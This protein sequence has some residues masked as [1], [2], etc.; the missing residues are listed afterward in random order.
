MD[1]TRLAQRNRQLAAFQHRLTWREKFRRAL[2]QAYASL[3]SPLLQKPKRGTI[4]LIRPDHLGDV[5][6]TTPTIQALRQSSRLPKDAQLVGLVGP[7]S[8]EA[9]AA[10]PELDLVLTLPFPGFTRKPKESYLAPYMQAFQ[11]ARKVRQL[12]AEAAIILRP[13]HWW[14][15]M[16][17]YLAGVPRRIGYDLPD[18]R[19]F[20]TH[21]LPH[22]PDHTVMQSLR[23]VEWWTGPINRRDVRLSFPVADADRQYIN[24]LLAASGVPALR[25]IV[26]IHPGAGTPLKRW[27]PEHWAQVA[28]RLADRLD[29]TVVFTGSD[30]EHTQIWQ[31][32]NKMRHRGLSL[33]GD[34]NVPQLAAL[35]ARAVVALGPDSGPLHLAVASGTPTVHLFGPADPAEFGPFG[36]PT[37]QIVLTSDIGCRPCR[38]IDWPGDD[39]ANHPC[40]RDIKPQQVIEAAL[41]AVQR[42]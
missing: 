5:L 6:L 7:W 34:T 1:R 24:T 4:L 18:V 8:S 26:I 17:A 31:V 23:L 16:L 42:R 35:F 12:R 33:A 9:L 27:L 21:A 32:M 11:W 14:G 40:I 29:A 20:L 36:D 25:P 19:P 15:A 41:Q 28:D 2:L 30:R 10:Y 39:P 37:R 38:I 22:Q 13:D 3:P